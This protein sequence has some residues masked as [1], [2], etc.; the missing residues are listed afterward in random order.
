MNFENYA[1][2]T[3]RPDR[4][5]DRVLL[6]LRDLD[7]GLDLDRNLLP[8]MESGNRPV[9]A[10]AGQTAGVGVRGG[11]GRRLQKEVVTA[12]EVTAVAVVAVAA[13]CGEK[14]KR[15]TGKGRGKGKGR[16]K[17]YVREKRNERDSV[18][19]IK[20]APGGRDQSVK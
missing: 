3:I 12:E 17:S 9:G 14:K 7:L 19:K 11:T 5:R 13:A 8:E 4:G 10:E 16:E 18:K 20:I 15:R 2:S 1:A 6:P